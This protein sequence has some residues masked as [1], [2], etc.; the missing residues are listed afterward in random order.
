MQMNLTK[1]SNHYSLQSIKA[2][3]VSTF[4]TFDMEGIL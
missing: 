1:R 2:P 3:I 4:R